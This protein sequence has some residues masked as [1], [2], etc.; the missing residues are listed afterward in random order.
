[1]QSRYNSAWHKVRITKKIDIYCYYKYYHYF[2]FILTLSRAGCQK[3]KTGLLSSE[4]AKLESDLPQT[5]VDLSPRVSG[6]GGVGQ[7]G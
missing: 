6:V 3:K 4:F 7:E 1:M 2:I 5:G